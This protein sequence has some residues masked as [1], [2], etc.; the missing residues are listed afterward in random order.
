MSEI[1]DKINEGKKML[2]VLVLKQINEKWLMDSP[3]L[4]KQY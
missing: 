4:R 1:L 2:N 3:F